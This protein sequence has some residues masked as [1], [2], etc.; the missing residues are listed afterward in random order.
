[1]IIVATPIAI[2]NRG[3]RQNQHHNGIG[4]MNYH[5]QCQR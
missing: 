3:T 5:E 1:M 2:T 4:S